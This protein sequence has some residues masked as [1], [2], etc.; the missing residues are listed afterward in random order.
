MSRRGILPA[1]RRRQIT[2]LVAEFGVLRIGDVA[3][4]FGVADETVRRDFLS[5]ERL[6]VLTREHGGASLPGVDTE[7]PY[8]RRERS[9]SAAKRLI[10]QAAA[11]IVRDG[12]T[13]ILDSGT[14]TIT[15]SSS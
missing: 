12:S 15:W 13:I 14:T 5:L 2:K 1:E 4:R 6:G 10:A 8:R 3:A 7:T 11:L 9:Q